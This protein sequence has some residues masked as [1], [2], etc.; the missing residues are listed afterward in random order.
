MSSHRLHSVP[1]MV[2]GAAIACLAAGAVYAS[3]GH[4]NPLAGMGNP[5]NEFQGVVL[6]VSPTVIQSRPGATTQQVGSEVGNTAANT[7]GGAIESA[8]GYG[9]LGNLGADLASAVIRGVAHHGEK[10]ISRHKGIRVVVKIK[11]QFGNSRLVSIEQ[12]GQVSD[13]KSGEKVLVDQFATGAMRVE[14]L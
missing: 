6:K 11:G 9:M 3:Q 1:V 10:A 4:V 13:F 8:G 14:S 2:I 5:V 7:A 12:P